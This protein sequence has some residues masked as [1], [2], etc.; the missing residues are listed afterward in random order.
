MLCSSVVIMCS[1]V[2]LFVSEWKVYLKVLII[3]G[4]LKQYMTTTL[5][6]SEYILGL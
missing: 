4:G 2:T 3:M 6:D 1:L 5:G